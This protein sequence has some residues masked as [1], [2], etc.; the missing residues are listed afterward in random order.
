MKELN[1]THYRAHEM[2]QTTLYRAHGKNQITHYRME[3]MKYEKNQ[4]YRAHEKPYYT[5]YKANK[6]NKPTHTLY[7]ELMKITKLLTTQL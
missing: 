5:H 3:L 1:Y 7:V 6:R 2:I 4:R